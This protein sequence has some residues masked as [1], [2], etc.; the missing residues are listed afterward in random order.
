MDKAIPVSAASA[1][2]L[3][4]KA[5]AALIESFTSRDLPVPASVATAV[6]F[7]CGAIVALLDSFS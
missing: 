7:N 6:R 3:N 5:S 1:I 4:L 2:A